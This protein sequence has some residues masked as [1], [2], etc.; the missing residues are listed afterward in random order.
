M[1]EVI[2][3]LARLPFVQRI[4][5]FGSLAGADWDRWSDMD[6]LVVTQARGQFLAAW[7]AL[8][9][10]KPVFYHHPLCRA[11]PSGGH[12]LGNVFVGES[13]FHCLD[14]NLLSAHEYRTPGALDRFGTLLEVYRAPDTPVIETDADMDVTQT[15]TPDEDRIATGIHFTKKAIKQVLRG[16]PAHG[17][18]K[19]FAGQLRAIM[20][21][22]P[23]DY[24]VVGGN[25]GQVAETYVTIADC[26]LGDK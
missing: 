3:I 23:V 17:D 18:L 15:L 22:Y 16:H 5:V 4:A 11:E 9:D 7:Q 12:M 10:A 6:M 24:R 21:D 19:R 2:A 20:R 13:V 25:I 26:L 8:H 1:Q 14:L